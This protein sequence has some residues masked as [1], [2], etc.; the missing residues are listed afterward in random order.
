MTPA[1]GT[2]RF[3]F[4]TLR[5]GQPRPYADSVY[6]YIIT[7]EWIKSTHPR[8]VTPV[9]E[10]NDISEEVVKKLI[11]GFAD[12][13]FPEEKPDWYETTVTSFTKIGPGKWRLQANR[14]YT[15]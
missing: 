14:A 7:V 8:D 3:M 2:R 10:P 13:K 15:D 5:A 1:P 9:W 12:V 11:R 6:E 4:E